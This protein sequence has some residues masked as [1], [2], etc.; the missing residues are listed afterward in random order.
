MTKI[1]PPCKAVHLFL[2]QDG[3]PPRAQYDLLA[4]LYAIMES[5]VDR[6]FG[7]DSV[8]QA[9]DP[10]SIKV[11]LWP[12]FQPRRDR[13]KRSARRQRSHTIRPQT[14]RTSNKGR[15]MLCRTKTL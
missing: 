8:Q 9:T 5:F 12:H 3:E 1:E 10:S 13:R 4:V 6:A 7:A 2:E 14:A 15:E 11:P